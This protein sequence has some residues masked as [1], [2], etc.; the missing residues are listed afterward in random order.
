MSVSEI[1]SFSRGSTRRT[2]ASRNELAELAS[3]EGKKNG[4]ERDG[5]NGNPTRERNQPNLSLLSSLYAI[6]RLLFFLSLLCL[7]A[8]VPMSRISILCNNIIADIHAVY[9]YIYM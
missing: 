8:I 7:L 3:S 2:F 1:A 6:L 9:T 4:T 5:R